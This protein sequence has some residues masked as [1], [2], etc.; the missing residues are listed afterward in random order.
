MSGV[1]GERVGKG[2]RVLKK[3]PDF[4]ERMAV[5]VVVSFSSDGSMFI[6]DF[7][8]PSLDIVADE[9]GKLIG[10]R[11]EME[12]SVRIFLSP[13]VCKKATLQK[14]CRSVKS[15]LKYSLYIW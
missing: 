7:L 15:I 5:A 1:A 4:V 9:R 6:I 11:G 12:R 2:E 13:I 10:L 3:S 8:K 14:V